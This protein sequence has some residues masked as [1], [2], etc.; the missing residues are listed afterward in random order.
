MRK[1]DARRRLQKLRKS[2]PTAPLPKKEDTPEW[3]YTIE[4][5]RGFF[6]TASEV[7]DDVFGPDEDRIGLDMYDAVAREIEATDA[8]IRLLVPGCGTGLELE[9][10]FERAPNA[11]VKGIDLSGGMLAKLREKFRSRAAQ[12]ELLENSYVDLPLGKSVYDYAIATL[13]AHHLSP[14][15]KSRFYAAVRAALKPGGKYIEGDQSSSPEDEAKTLKC[16]AD[17]IAGLPGGD[18]AEWN[19]DVTLCPETN[20]R[21]LREA[22]FNDVKLTWKSRSGG[23]VV[24]V[25]DPDAAKPT[26]RLCLEAQAPRTY[27]TRFP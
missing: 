11:R 23:N 26:G 9:G 10:L 4:D 6:D 1:E 19:Y 17:Y 8:P 3:L 21:L 20:E 22:G 27:R 12:I 15:A 16:F 25:A 14:D 18:R 5:M 13:T 2:V 24:L 7:W